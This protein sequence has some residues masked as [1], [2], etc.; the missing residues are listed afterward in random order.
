MMV[1]NTNAIFVHTEELGRKFHN[2]RHDVYYTGKCYFA[3]QIIKNSCPKM[4]EGKHAGK[5]YEEILLI[6]REYAVNALA[7]CT[8]RKLYT[9]PLR[10]LSNWMKEM[11]KKD[12]SLKTDVLK[13]E[14]D[15]RGMIL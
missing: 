2:S 13:K 11:V 10:K 3:E 7:V 1:L 9:S 5:T 15:I 12:P 14:Q 6:D 4:Y 8:V